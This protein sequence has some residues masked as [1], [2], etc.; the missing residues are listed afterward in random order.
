MYGKLFES[1][2][3]G[4]LVEDWEALITFQQMIILCD[5]D[6]VLD[7]TASAIARRTGIPI[8][9]IKHGISVLESPDPESRSPNSKGKRIIRLND[10]REWGWTIVNHKHYRDLRTADDRREYMRKYMRDK[11]EKEKLTNV[12]ESSHVNE[13][14]HT[15]TNTYTNKVKRKGF[16]KPSV[17]EVSEYCLSR[18]NNISAEGFIDFYTSNGWKV[19]KNP[20]KDWK[21]AVRTWERRENSNEKDTR[22]RAKRLSDKLDDIAR[23]DIEENGFPDFVD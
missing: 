12:N 18:S 15:Y 23:K 11:R 22:S 4:T 14:A 17:Q 7:M 9:H 16:I 2:Y 8:K 21:S 13:L 5:S 19:G 10:H 3:D 20:M 6:G 1:I